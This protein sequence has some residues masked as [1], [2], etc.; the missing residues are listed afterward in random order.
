MADRVVNQRYR[1]VRRLGRGA[2]SDVFLVHDLAGERRGRVESDPPLRAL[3]LVHGGA[4]ADDRLA[5]EFRRLAGLRHDRLV[6]VRDLERVA[7]PAPAGFA[8]GTLFFTADY[9]DG[10]SP[11]RAVAAAEQRDAALLVIAED[12]AAALAY[13][14]AAGLLHCDVKP[15]NVLCPGDGRAVLV[16]LG[17]S[18]ARGV[19]GAARG[20]VAYMSREALAGTPD[21]RS[22]L[23]G[24]GATLYHAATGR[25]PYGDAA[26]AE[27]VRAICDRAP[28]PV[29]ERAPWLHPALADLITRLLA[30]LTADRPSAAAVVLD[31]LARIR[32]ELDPGGAEV[33][34][35]P[36]WRAPLLPPPLVGRDEVLRELSTILEG[37]DG[38][39]LVR[40]VGPPG[41]G[42]RTVIAEAMRRH[43]LEVAAGRARPIDFVAGD[44]EQVDRELRRRGELS[45]P[46]PAPA[47]LALA[48]FTE[49]FL[50]AACR[51]G[52]ANPGHRLVVVL[53]GEPEERQRAV[54]R[55]VAAGHPAARDAG[56]LLLARV[57][58]SGSDPA[59]DEDGVRELVLSPLDVEQVAAVAGAMLGE[60]VAAS[61]AEELGRVSG[62]VP[63]FL[64]EL[65]RAAAAAADGPVDQ[66]SV[67]ELVGRDSDLGSV[68]VRRVAGLDRDHAAVVEGLAVHDGSATLPALAAS[69]EQPADQVYALV[70]DLAPSG[71][72]AVDTGGDLP[73]IRLPSAAHAA[74]LHAAIPTAR[75]NLLHR[76]ALD[77]LAGQPADPV[78]EA[79]HLLVT[80]PARRAAAACQ[81]ASRLLLARGQGQRALEMSRAAVSRATGSAAATAHLALAEVA[82]LVG[83]YADAEGAAARA[84]RSR[85]PSLRRRGA[86]ALARARHKRGDLDGAEPIYRELTDQG[87]A[88]ARGG[89][90]RLLV[91]RARYAEA[92]E[93]AAIEDDQATADLSPARALRLESAGLARLYQGDTAG[94]ERCFRRLEE[95]AHSAGDRALIGRALGLRGMAAQA[96]GEIAAAADLYQRAGVEA[97]AAADVHAAAVYDINQAT[98][99]SERGRHGEAVVA[100][101]SALVQ[102]GRLGQV[103]ERAAANYN[104]GIALL[105]LGELSAA[106]RAAQRAA[107]AAEAHGTPQMLLYARLLDGDVARR[108]GDLERAT[109]AYQAAIEGGGNRRDR[110]LAQLDLALVLAERGDAAA[111]DALEAATELV[112]SADERDRVLI[113]RARIALI[114]GDEAGD[115]IAAIDEARRRIR[116]SGRIDQAWRCEVVAA[117]LARAAGDEARA[118]TLAGAA[119]ATVDDILAA[120]PEARRPGLTTDPDLVA[121]VALEGD[122][123]RPGRLASGAGEPPAAPAPDRYLR[124]LLAL[125]RRLNSELRLPPLLDQVIDTAIELT[126][127]ERGFL[128]LR[129][130]GAG[131]ALDI[132]VARNIEQNPLHGEELRVSRSIAERAARSGEVVLTVDAAFDERFD[133]VE[134]VAALRLRSVLAVPLRQKG[135]ITGT[136]YVDHRFRS[137][138]FDT[139]AIELVR[140]LADIAAVA[141]ENAQLVEANRQRQDEIAALNR[142]LEAEVIE[143]EAELATVRSRLIADP[144]AEL[145]HP[146]D[147]IVGGSPA[148][149]DM[150]RA[151]DRATA[152]SLPVVIAG[153]SGTGKELVARALHHNGQRRERP[154]VAVNCGAMPEHLLESELFG[155]TRGA[156][157]GAERDRRGLFE[158]ASGG[159][160]FLDEVA[161]TSLAMQ[162]RLLR[163]LQEGEIRRV[164]DERTRKVDVR[165]IA[166]TNKELGELV[167]EGRFREDLFYRLNVL[168]IDVPPLRQRIED[169]PALAGHILARLG[170]PPAR[171]TKAAVARLC[172][173]VWPG[174]VRELE[175]ELARAAALGG[176]VIDVDDLSSHLRELAR[177]APVG[178][179][180]DLKLKEQVEALERD[181]VEEAMRRTDGNQTAAA[182]LLGLSRYGLQKKLKRYGIAGSLRD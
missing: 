26:G 48:R 108:E 161:D 105:A 122:L 163:A 29:A 67:R 124:R 33:E 114:R 154:F 32:E 25:P 58:P 6:A 166:A 73:R 76:R 34:M 116:S 64:V 181:L 91:A 28:P 111:A 10:V 83:E 8:P 171:L 129:Q 172:G 94:S 115:L 127:A 22:D 113:A 151:L 128:L 160:L 14:H 38:T 71:F 131:D 56:L 93:V 17:L 70:A 165:I 43:Q 119:R 54:T 85:D 106:R 61:W 142:R 13:L 152:T 30:P 19:V 41:I 18:L 47:E 80:G 3:K 55:A 16:D 45:A 65:V 46:A 177:T 66:V 36:A 95:E 164:G 79:H 162:A 109:A 1:I 57:D 98:A 51:P 120:T 170:D 169:L 137:A 173:H 40:L 110:L 72:L 7:A 2:D 141:I 150:L 179:R 74:A 63:R 24:L 87:D 12:V 69:L 133:S 176:E 168:R 44:I 52:L 144:R 37:D 146:Y 75:R 15:A 158:V 126:C 175:N 130:P 145:R 178:G 77:W 4:G 62:G 97:R 174:N 88:D 68:I 112:D 42:R 117:R 182:K 157:T 155:H 89:Y 84:A 107:R 102:L 167:A 140:E 92:E 31:H 159:T 149:V 99:H 21:P 86:L 153:E 104:R 96:A 134:S 90:A 118:S 60:P 156:F 148:M 9:V 103:A 20:T 53:S 100:L 121:L 39:V 132:V 101:G 180:D 143:K 50:S 139:E 125:S 59:G 82:L 5:G 81:E 138:A 78:A 23:Y 136:I 49:E 35:S 27:L 123:G 11:E 147:A 135:R